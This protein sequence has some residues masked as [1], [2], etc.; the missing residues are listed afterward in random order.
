MRIL[1]TGS[2]GFIGSKIVNELIG[3][4]HQVLGLLRPRA[5]DASLIANGA[6]VHRGDLDDVQ[7]LR[8][9]VAMADGVIHTAFNHDFSRFKANCED[10]RR[11]IELFGSQLAGSDRPLIIISSTATV[12]AAPG[13]PAREEDPIKSSDISP[14]AAS[15]EAAAAVLKRGVNVSTVRLPQVHDP[16]KQGLISNLIK[17]AREKG[18]SAYIGDGSNRWPAV[19]VLDA[20]RLFR[21]AIEK[22]ESGNKY[23]AVAE[24]GIPVRE[25]AE[26]ISKGLDV[27]LVSV[28]ADDAASH[29]GWLNA[30]ASRDLIAS[31]A[32]TRELLGWLPTGPGVLDDLGAMRHSLA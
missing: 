21:L 11:V 13:Q 27:P 17:I 23:H 5:S 24:E 28:S 22:H 20:A 3:A 25:I 6:A 16:V 4:G 29:F 8:R 9:G 30:F 10:D 15:E 12:S 2:T 19:H 1:V 18:V 31:S 26:A 32:Q 14:R 7:S